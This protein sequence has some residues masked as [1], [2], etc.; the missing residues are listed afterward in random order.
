MSDPTYSQAFTKEFYN[1]NVRNLSNEDIQRFHKEMF[2][3][4]NYQIKRENLV[5]YCALA[6]R[7]ALNFRTNIF[8]RFVDTEIVSFLEEIGIIKLV[9]KSNFSKLNDIF[10]VSDPYLKPD[11]KIRYQPIHEDLTR[12]VISR[13]LNESRD[14]KR[15]K[16]LEYSESREEYNSRR[17]EN[18][19]QDRINSLEKECS[20]IFR[21]FQEKVDESLSKEST[22]KRLSSQIENKTKEHDSLLSFSE[23]LKEKISDMST[24]VDYMSEEKKIAD[25]EIMRLY[26]LISQT[27]PKEE[28]ANHLQMKISKLERMNSSHLCTIN[29]LTKQLDSMHQL[30]SSTSSQLTILQKK[31][32]EFINRAEKKEEENTLLLAEIALLKEEN[33]FLLR[34]YRGEDATGEDSTPRKRKLSNIGQSDD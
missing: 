21:L 2:K 8:V 23:E 34:K 11:S 33:T 17:D 13:D 12:Q 16:L 19:L 26:C 30:Y 10:T 6:C 18:F 32:T 29:E 9:L 7:N 3:D 31:S 28:N 4:K 27:S 15:Q 5:V 22:I 20:L 25:S 1:L 24:A 14:L